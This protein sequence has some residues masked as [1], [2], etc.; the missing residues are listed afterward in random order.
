MSDKQD[1]VGARTPADLERKYKFKSFSE[2]MGVADDARA[3]AENASQ[4]VAKLDKSLNAEEVFNRLTNNGELQGLYRD[5]DGNLYVNATYIQSIEELLAK[6]LTMTG[7]F[8]N[9]ASVFLAPG[10]EEIEIVQNHILGNI[11]IPSELIPYY[12]TNNDGQINLTDMANMRLAQMGL[13]SLAD[14]MESAKPST[15]KLTIDL[16]N[17]ERFLT[18]KGKNMWGREVEKYLGTNFTNVKNPDT[19]KR[20]EAIESNIETIK[21]HLGL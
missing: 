5:E 16:A 10:D 4:E 3:K 18:I 9:T 2:V 7:K 14:V 1:R 17:P 8:I 20:L 11:S 21:T 15:V 6:D 19:E 12:D 13:L